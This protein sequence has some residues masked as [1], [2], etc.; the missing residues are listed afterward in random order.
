MN[1]MKNIIDVKF[2]FDS[3]EKKREFVLSCEKRFFKQVD[4]IADE[5]LGT[6]GVKFIALSGPTCSGKTTASA[7]LNFEFSERGH[8][9]KTISIDD[10]YLERSFLEE[11]AR[12]LGEVVDFDSPTTI[13]IERLAECVDGICKKKTV[14]LPKYSFTTGK[15]EIAE[16]FDSN[17][18]DLYI[19]E[20][21]Q[22]I[23]P[24]VREILS[25]QNYVSVNICPESE[26]KYGD[27]IFTHD[28]LRFARRL[29]RDYKYRN[30]PTE[31]TFFLWDGVRKNEEKYIMPF[32][33]TVDFKID[34][35]MAYEPCVIKNQ[36]IKYLSEVKEDSKYYEEA[37]TLIKE[38]LTIPDI[39]ESFVPK[40]SIFREFIG[41]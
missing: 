8:R 31:Y 14:L 12:A 41:G 1:T 15:T 9:V 39:D 32:V 35:S 24:N 28:E 10:F 4:K 29:V 21:I 2:D 5:I 25:C 34:S 13:N 7:R 37:A 6:E 22:A 30:A 20:G 27:S 38:Y 40:N 3:D 16:E 18:A 11:R 26:V 17:D 36:F 23:Y 33:D 19:V